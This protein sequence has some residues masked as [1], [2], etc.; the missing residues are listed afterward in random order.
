MTETLALA[1]AV[2]A[3]LGAAWLASRRSWSPAAADNRGIALQTVIV[4]V[5]M[6]VIAGGVA[7]VLLTRGNEVIGD[8]QAQDIA[9]QEVASEEE[10]K[11]AA[12]RLTRDEDRG[13]WAS[14]TCTITSNA[15]AEDFTDVICESFRKADGTRATY[16]E[17]SNR[18]VCTI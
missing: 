11:S 18:S 13:A 2:P 8:L 7:G 16:S 12:Q 17:T 1:I 4:I 15:A 5:V 9:S 3:A 10:C 6:L 14:S